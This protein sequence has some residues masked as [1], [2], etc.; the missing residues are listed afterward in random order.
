MVFT[1]ILVFVDYLRKLRI[2]FSE[3]VQASTEDLDYIH[4][5][6]KCGNITR[7]ILDGSGGPCRCPPRTS[8]PHIDAHPVTSSLVCILRSRSPSPR[9]P[10]GSKSI[11]VD[12]EQRPMDVL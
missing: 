8:A 12:I 7:V 1:V 11:R 4:I 2:L 10:A 9:G 6:T 5:G 3:S